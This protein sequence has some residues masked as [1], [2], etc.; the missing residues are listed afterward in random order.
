LA[1]RV[2]IFVGWVTISIVT[3]SF[4]NHSF[5][6]GWLARDN[7]SGE[8][9]MRSM[10]LDIAVNDAGVDSWTGLRRAGAFLE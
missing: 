5:H 4:L 8:G 6:Q 10:H 7:E 3:V 1:K 2:P 9:S